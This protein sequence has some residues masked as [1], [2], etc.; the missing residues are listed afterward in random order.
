MI[1]QRILFRLLFL[2]SAFALCFV[3]IAYSQG[4]QYPIADQVAQKL[5]QHYQQTSCQEL[6]K[7]RMQP[8]S[9]KKEEMASKAAEIMRNDPQMRKHFINTVAAPIANK[10]FECGMIP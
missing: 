6:W 4:S 10:M 5:I 1:R 9:P 3:M 8:Q 7:E 2:I